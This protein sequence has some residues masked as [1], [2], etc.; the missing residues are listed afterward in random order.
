MFFG[1]NVPPAR[2]ED[3]RAALANADALLVAGS[4][5]MVYSGYRFALQA[6]D[7]GQPIAIVN[8]GRTRGDELAM[9]KVE[10]DVGTVLTEAVSRVE[11]SA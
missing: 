7:A 8:R 3:A 4:S 1:E 10:G 9:L 2:Y 11:A 5:L 6:R